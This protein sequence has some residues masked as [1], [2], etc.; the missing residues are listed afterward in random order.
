MKKTILY[1]TIILFSII[2]SVCFSYTQVPS[3]EDAYAESQNTGQ[4]IVVIFGAD[5]CKFCKNLDRDIKDN[6][7]ILDD[8]IYVYVNIDDRTDLKTEYKV[9]TI[10]HCIVLE[11]NIETKKKI[12]YKGI[13]D[14]RNWIN[15]K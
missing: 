1:A 10:P 15:K 3:L 6:T 7:D 5:W 2:N 11:N 13:T 4:A 14:F 9:K 12:G 8:Y